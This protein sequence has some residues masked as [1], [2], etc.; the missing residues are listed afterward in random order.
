MTYRIR[1]TETVAKA[2]KQFHPA[3]KK[4][5]K[6]A[7]KQLADNPYQG[8]SLQEDLEDFLSYK[9]NRYRVIYKIDDE[10]KRINIFQIGHRR[11]VYELFASLLKQN[12][13]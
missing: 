6:S 8:K 11:D 9:I 7:L 10:N 3:N 2:L 12:E 13:K 4:I 5:I 1:F